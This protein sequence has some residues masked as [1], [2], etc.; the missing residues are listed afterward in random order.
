MAVFYPEDNRKTDRINVHLTKEEYFAVEAKAQAAGLSPSAYVRKLF[1]ERK[2]LP[3]RPFGDLFIPNHET[4]RDISVTMAII[5]TKQAL[6]GK[7]RYKYSEKMAKDIFARM[8]GMTP[9]RN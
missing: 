7:E 4:A 8:Q 2:N 5:L 1:L 9:P 3:N 6:F